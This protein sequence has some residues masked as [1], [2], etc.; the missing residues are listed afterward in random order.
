[1]GLK[2][3]SDSTIHQHTITDEGLQQLKTIRYQ[4]MMVV[5]LP[6][7]AQIKPNWGL[8]IPTRP[9]RKLGYLLS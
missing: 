7:T 3:L 1:M 2:L 6:L 4:Q 9:I 5:S 8:T